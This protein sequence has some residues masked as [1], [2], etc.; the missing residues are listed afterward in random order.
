MEE[1]FKKGDYIVILRSKNLESSFIKY[2]HCYRQESSKDSFTTKKDS[3]GQGCSTN[4]TFE[5]KEWWRYATKA[6]RVEYERQ[7]K[8]FDTTKFT[9]VVNDNYE[10]Y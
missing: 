1:G 4:I 7:N 3:T 10:I 8:P 9:P 6:E 5:K 2:G